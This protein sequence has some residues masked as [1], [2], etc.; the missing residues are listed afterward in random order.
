MAFIKGADTRRGGSFV[1][2]P[3]AELFSAAAKAG[4]KGAGRKRGGRGA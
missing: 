3:A 1:V 2:R 4:Q